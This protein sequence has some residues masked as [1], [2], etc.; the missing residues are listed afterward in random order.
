[1]GKSLPADQPHDR[2]RQWMLIIAVLNLVLNAIKL[3][4]PGLYF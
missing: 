4:F 3:L 1:M 2:T